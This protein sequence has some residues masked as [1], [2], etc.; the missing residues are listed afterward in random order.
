MTSEEG[1]QEAER[2]ITEAYKSRDLQLYLS[3]L[4][5]TRAC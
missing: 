3:N 4:Q 1:Y 5:L 2:R